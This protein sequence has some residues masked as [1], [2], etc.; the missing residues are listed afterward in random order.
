[1]RPRLVRGRKRHLGIALVQPDTC[2]VE[3]GELHTTNAYCRAGRPRA[4]H[5][6]AHVFAD[7]LQYQ[8]DRPPT[9]RFRFVLTS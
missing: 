2:I 3:Y 6:Y 8:L 4:G 1:M 7:G 5:V 9:Y